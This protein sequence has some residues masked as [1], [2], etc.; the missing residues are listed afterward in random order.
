MLCCYNSSKFGRNGKKKLLKQTTLT[1]SCSHNIFC[2]PK[3]P[4]KF[5]LFNSNQRKFSVLKHLLVMSVKKY[6]AHLIIPRD[7]IGGN[8]KQ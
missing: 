6:Q 5:L 3:L 4:V 7:K 2:F 1:T 8:F